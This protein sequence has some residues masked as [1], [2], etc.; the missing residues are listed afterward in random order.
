MFYYTR[1]EWFPGVIFMAVSSWALVS[2]ILLTCPQYLLF[3][4][5][6]A[7]Y[8]LPNVMEHAKKF[9]NFVIKRSYSSDPEQQLAK[10][11][12]A[13]HIPI[14]SPTLTVVLYLP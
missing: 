10:V 9:D 14:I 5:E 4:D 1:W 7:A 12:L 2:A 3:Q 8:V 11:H 6:D 13:E